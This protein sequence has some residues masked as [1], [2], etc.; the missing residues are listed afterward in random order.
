M[1]LDDSSP[2]GDQETLPDLPYDKPSTNSEGVLH[3]T[4]EDTSLLSASATPLPPSSP[5]YIAHLTPR[6][7][8]E[9][10]INE[11]QPP[12]QKP[13]T[14]RPLNPDRRLSTPLQTSRR[15]PTNPH[16]SNLHTPSRPATS[17]RASSNLVPPFADSTTHSRSSSGATIRE[18][19][20]KP[21]ITA[22]SVAQDHF[23]KELAA[24]DLSE[25]SS[26]TV[27]I[28]RDSCYGHRYSRPRTSKATLST[29]VER[30]ERLHA[31]ILGAS[32]AYVR[33]GGRHA[34]GK[35]PPHPNQDVLAPPFN[36]RRTTRS[37]PLNNFAVTQVHGQKWMEELQIMCDSAEGKLAMNGRE[38]VR[39]I[40]YGK[41]EAGNPLPKLH[42]GDLYL[43]S[44]SLD[45]LQ[46]C[47]GGVCE[48]VDTVF[49]AG[50]T[51]RAFVCIRPPG[52]HCSS[53]F[54]SGFCW[55]NNV[56][57]G[58][59]HAAMTQG[60]T[61]AAIIDFDLHHGDGSQAIAWDHNR[62]A[63]GSLP[64]NASAY[65][66]T[67]IGYFSLHDI[68]SY[69]CEWGDEEKIKNASLCVENAHGQS[70]WNTHLEPWKNHTDFWKLYESKYS[71][72][73]E[74]ARIFLRHHTKRLGGANSGVRAK[75]AIFLSAGF[76]AS[77]WE[78]AGM[79]R[80]K[81]NVPIDFYA[82]FTSDIVKLAAEED[83]GVDGRIIS[84]LEGGYSDRALTSGVLSHLCGLTEDPAS[85]S[86]EFMHT[87]SGT[88]LTK[89]MGILNI[90]NH[91]PVA[92][93]KKSATGPNPTSSISYN[94]GWWTTSNLEAL[95]MLVNP[96][97]SP[98]AQ[99]K[100]KDK[101]GNYSSPTQASTAKMIDPA[102]E[103]RS[104]SGQT[105]GRA[106]TEPEPV[107]PPPEVD[108]AVASYELSRLLIP[109]DRQTLSCRHDELNAE[110]TKARRD[111]QSAIGLPSNDISTVDQKMQLRDRKAKAPA[112]E[113]LVK[114]AS[115]A[116]RR[117][118]IAAV[119]DLPDPNGL[120]K[121]NNKP[122]VG[123]AN[124]RPRR[125]SSAGSSILSA[126]ESMSLNDHGSQSSE[127][128]SV[129]S[130]GVTPDKVRTL[131]LVTKP[132]RAP[133]QKKIRQSAAT[134]TQP[135]KTKTSPRKTGP[136][137][138]VPK[139]QSA[140]VKSSD[141]ASNGGGDIT[142]DEDQPAPG[143]IDAAKPVIAADDAD[144]L[145]SGMKKMKI[146][147]KVRSPEEIATSERKAAEDKDKQKK[148]R[149]PRK[150]VLPKA[151]KV[152]VTK[153]RRPLSAVSAICSSTVDLSRTESHKATLDI[154]NT[155]YTL[156]E[157]Q[158]EL[159]LQTN[160]PPSANEYVPV[161]AIAHAEP[162]LQPAI[163]APVAAPVN[164]QTIDPTD[165]A[166]EDFHSTSEQPNLG[167]PINTEPSPSSPPLPTHPDITNASQPSI[168][169]FPASAPTTAKRTRADLPQFTASSPIPFAKIDPNRPSPQFIKDE[170]NPQTVDDLGLF[171]VSPPTNDT[172][173]PEIHLDLQQQEQPKGTG[174][175]DPSIWEVP[176]TPRP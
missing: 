77:E 53:N 109:D 10:A 89:Q 119:G 30:P 49:G 162:P 137:P 20:R 17:R 73:L 139:T 126:L 2:L 13:P 54:P 51:K 115:N 33:T 151:V 50:T 171:Q 130:R 107:P 35:F 82:R 149:A 74:K 125:R 27:V 124:N 86:P 159:V 3:S 59:A 85:S 129:V 167:T 136:A 105:E 8:M 68:N 111:R 48:A 158:P 60:L 93:S 101:T 154:N 72:L 150:P 146:N 78:G 160:T 169:K 153:S 6:L 29:I 1:D 170:K 23:K 83:L 118:T 121:T 24:H 123:I 132:Q 106:S 62:K 112:A 16:I 45:A 144:A 12:A 37:I 63:A 95:E 18:M 26:K 152:P 98:S 165:L 65:S 47:L 71:I 15:S 9:M 52:H 5:A 134:K 61:H 40:G 34:G 174:A 14:A 133:V 148:A 4:R 104:L 94:P 90:N 97:P 91:T 76:D 102:R 142:P 67:P 161:A 99:I 41:D 100:L 88:G 46:G 120:Q 70:I 166:M 36:I 175:I 55:L 31:C 66:K 80:H 140:F 69:P 92:E 128:G 157:Q 87:G 138:V 39:P 163:P 122:A 11:A 117:K 141:D 38:L 176:E 116:D 42:E 127:T 172:T 44:E 64:K 21:V 25:T 43:C 110:A 7:R 156:P 145:S 108:W 56:H 131:T 173:S 143:P 135:V 79:Q 103:W 57:V 168:A 96:A 113:D 81:V 75:A 155:P 28:I 32:T 22:N 58:I 147:L 84:V 19:E 114:D 164:I